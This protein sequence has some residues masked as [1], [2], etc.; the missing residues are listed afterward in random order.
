MKEVSAEARAVA[1]KHGL[2]EEIVQATF[3]RERQRAKEQR[4]LNLACSLS[5]TGRIPRRRGRFNTQLAR[6]AARVYED[7][8]GEPFPGG[9]ANA[10]ISR[11]Y[12]GHLN[13]SEGAWS[14]Y[15]DAINYDHGYPVLL[16]S[17]WPAREALKDLT[18]LEIQAF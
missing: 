6:K 8:K 15:L 14:W 2:D 13:R 12:A 5:R 7:L 16:G 10:C 17:P 1:L 4:D 11:T 9:P 18:K 3:D